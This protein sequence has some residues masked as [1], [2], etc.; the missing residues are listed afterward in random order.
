MAT[1]RSVFMNLPPSCL[2]I[3]YRQLATVHRGLLSQLSRRPRRNTSGAAADFAARCS[4]GACFC[5][6]EAVQ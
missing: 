1:N 3:C 6:K 5:T 4:S 2:M